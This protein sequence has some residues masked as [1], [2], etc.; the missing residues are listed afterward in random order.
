[1]P[2]DAKL[3]ELACQLA[4]SGDYANVVMIERELELRGLLDGPITTNQY[5]RNLLTRTCHAM[6]GGDLDT[7]VMGA[8][9]IKPV[10][11]AAAQ[12]VAR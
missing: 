8:L 5:K 12:T 9:G 6:R 1:M 7:R 10:S 3:W 11:Q 2:Y 4:R